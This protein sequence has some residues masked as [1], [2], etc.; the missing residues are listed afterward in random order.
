MRVKKQDFREDYFSTN[1]IE[2]NKLELR[3][4]EKQ[5]EDIDIYRNKDASFKS[6]VRKEIDRKK[7]IINKYSPPQLTGKQK[8]LLLNRKKF[9]EDK[10][11]EVTVTDDEDFS[12]DHYVRE[13]ARK[14]MAVRMSNQYE[15]MAKELRRINRTLDPENEVYNSLNYLKRR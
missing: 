2:K 10:L 11:K 5:L 15:E 9:I 1:S 12:N 13:M 3:S 6:N 8:D 14:K 4:L 7:A